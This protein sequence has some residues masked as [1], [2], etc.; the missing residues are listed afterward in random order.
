MTKAVAQVKHLAWNELQS[1]LL[2]A[3]APSLRI[4][5]AEAQ[6]SYSTLSRRIDAL[7]TQLNCRLFDRLPTGLSLTPQGE[8]LMETAIEMEQLSIKTQRRLMGTASQLRGTVRLSLVDVLAL[9]PVMPVLAKFAELHPEIEPD[10]D[11]SYRASDL[12]RNEADLVLRLSSAPPENLIGRKLWSC[13]TAVYGATDYINDLGLTDAAPKSGRVVGFEY[14]GRVPKWRQDTAFSEFPLYG[15]MRSMAVQH[16]A[17]KA[18][19][20]LAQL[21]CFIGAP[22]KSLTRLSPPSRD[23]RFNLWLLR[24][25]DL[26]NTERVSALANFL[27]KQ[28]PTQIAALEDS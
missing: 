3:R 13:A 20:G 19:M 23:P 26:R 17:C 1:F 27:A 4:A 8:E 15:Q 6:V 28:L 7:E 10:I 14:Q 25:P 9:H 24:H 16:A 11:I 2:A 5:A 21:P 22:D 18:G 12:E